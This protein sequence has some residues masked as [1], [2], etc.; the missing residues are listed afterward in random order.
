MR[1]GEPIPRTGKGQ[2]KVSR[3]SCFSRYQAYAKP[4]EDI[5][6]H[7]EQFAACADWSKGAIRVRCPDCGYLYFR[8][9]RKTG[10]SGQFG[11]KSAGTQGNLE[12]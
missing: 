10:R 5:I 2:F 11:N 7:L 3:G 12:F 6:T 4:P 1:V 9:V 8:V